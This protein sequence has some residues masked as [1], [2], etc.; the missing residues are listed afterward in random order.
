M[1]TQA[2]DGIANSYDAWPAAI[3]HVYSPLAPKALSHNHELS[4]LFL[5]GPGQSKL[6]YSALLDAC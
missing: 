4:C 1:H 6:V 3:E 2:Q 5:D